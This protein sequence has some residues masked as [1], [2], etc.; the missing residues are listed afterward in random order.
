[1]PLCGRELA[2]VLRRLSRDLDAD[3]GRVVREGLRRAAQEIL[4]SAGIGAVPAET[5]D[6]L[7]DW[8]TRSPSK[9]DL[10][11]RLRRGVREYRVSRDGW[12]GSLDEMQRE[13]LSAA[14]AQFPIEHE[15]WGSILTTRQRRRNAYSQVRSILKT[16]N[17]EWVKNQLVQRQGA[18]TPEDFAADIAARARRLADMPVM[19]ATDFD[20][21]QRQLLDLFRSVM[22]ADLQ[23]IET[24]SSRQASATVRTYRISWNQFIATTSAVGILMRLNEQ[25]RAIVDVHPLFSELDSNFEPIEFHALHRSIPDDWPMPERFAEEVVQARQLLEKMTAASGKRSPSSSWSDWPDTTLAIPADEASHASQLQSHAAGAVATPEVPPAGTPAEPVRAD[26]QGAP[27][28]EAN[29]SSAVAEADSERLDMAFFPQGRPD[30]GYTRFWPS[31]SEC[32]SAVAGFMS[33]SAALSSAS[34]AWDFHLTYTR[35]G[36]SVTVKR[37]GLNVVEAGL[38][39]SKLALEISS[40]LS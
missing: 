4:D 32:A 20:S 7:T 16:L 1:M 31:P 27:R 34:G 23:S 28:L 10:G 26:T 9:R 12:V 3:A 40:L 17:P 38:Q 22:D 6:G 24:Y 15:P 30:D 36:Q 14:M 13:R 21:W 37:S 11:Q 5:V 8:M 35:G 19:D 29:F 33:R 25:H 2:E 18:D 39:A